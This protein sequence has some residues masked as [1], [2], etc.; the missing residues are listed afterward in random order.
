MT[1]KIALLCSIVLGL[2]GCASP[3]GNVFPLEERKLQAKALEK[4][5]QLAE[6]LLQ[7]EIIQSVNS[8]DQDA[9][10]AISK[11]KNEIHLS[12]QK[13][14]ASLK[15]A[16]V[17]EDIEEQRLLL[18]KILALNPTDSEAMASLRKLEWQ[19]AY[20]AASDKNASM[21]NWRIEKPVTKDSV[22]RLKQ[23]STNLP[24]RE[25]TQQS[26]QQRSTQERI[27]RLLQQAEQK[28][29]GQQWAQAGEILQQLSDFNGTSSLQTSKL[30]NMKKQLSAQYYSQGMRVLTSDIDQA[31]D[32][33]QTSLWYD[34]D[35]TKA[36]LQLSRASKMKQ[37]LEEIRNPK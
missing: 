37:N 15:K 27:D 36:R 12:L 17:E 25:K 6:A 30:I 20:Q 35:N 8:N 9:V 22:A 5:Q 26:L 16:E 19:D 28:L 18:L 4:R 21:A 34:P 1:F 11:L 32:D 3:V 24:K 13:H 33:L 7:W 14:Y 29:Q 23:P 10:I 2:A 31:I